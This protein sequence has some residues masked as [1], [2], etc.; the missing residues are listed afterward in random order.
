MTRADVIAL[1]DSYLVGDER[2]RAGVFA[3]IGAWTCD[4]EQAAPIVRAI[5]LIGPR[6]ADE[7]LIALRLV[8]DGKTVTDERIVE[9]RAIV[10]KAIAGDAEAR[11]AY[12]QQ[13]AQ[14]E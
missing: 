1:I 4:V 7:S 9:L 5:A 12:Q 13:I 8:V 2:D 3:K 11:L 14:P 10:K 6:A